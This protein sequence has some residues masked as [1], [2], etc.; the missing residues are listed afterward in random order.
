[1]DKNNDGYIDIFKTKNFDDIYQL[2]K[3]SDKYEEYAD[4]FEKLKQLVDEGEI[5]V[6]INNKSYDYEKKKYYKTIELKTVINESDIELYQDGT[7]YIHYLSLLKDKKRNILLSGTDLLYAYGIICK[8]HEITTIKLFDGSI[9]NFYGLPISLK[10]LNILSDGK[11]WYNK[12]GFLSKNN[13]NSKPLNNKNSTKNMKYINKNFSDIYI[14]L[15]M[16]DK[17]IESIIPT[18]KFYGVFDSI[19]FDNKGQL[20]ELIEKTDTYINSLIDGKEKK[21]TIKD[22]F[23]IIKKKLKSPVKES[24]EYYRIIFFLVTLFGDKLT[25]NNELYKNI[26]KNNNMKRKN[27]NKTIK[28]IKNINKNDK[29][30]IEILNY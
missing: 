22:F 15:I 16:E 1:M 28:T 18:L 3:L 21:I 4:I 7:A 14:D 27:N 20:L 23:T 30:I 24:R 5:S 25:Y 17:Y 26:T 29:F 13:N 2:Y 9:I 10:K 12:F 6:N 19:N 8:L 11:S